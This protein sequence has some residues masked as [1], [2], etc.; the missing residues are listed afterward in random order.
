MD[1][2]YI[3]N[4]ISRTQAQKEANRLALL[5]LQS[6][7]TAFKSQLY[8]FDTDLQETKMKFAELTADTVGDARVKTMLP[9]NMHLVAS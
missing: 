8:H 2:Q 1:S 7:L 9:V 4:I 3:Q 5:D 6:K